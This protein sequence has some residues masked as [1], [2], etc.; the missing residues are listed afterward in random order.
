[1]FY[2]Y[3][4]SFTQFLAFTGNFSFTVQWLSKWYI[5]S[6]DRASHNR[7]LDRELPFSPIPAIDLSYPSDWIP[8]HEFCPFCDEA[9]VQCLWYRTSNFHEVTDQFLSYG[10]LCDAGYTDFPFPQRL[11][12]IQE[13]RASLE[14]NFPQ[15]DRCNCHSGESTESF[16]DYSWVRNELVGYPSQPTAQTLELVPATYSFSGVP[17]HVH[18]EVYKYTSESLEQVRARYENNPLVELACGFPKVTLPFLIFV[19]GSPVP[20]LS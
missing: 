9:S 7:F 11:Q 17:W 10:D 16:L 8:S 4:G 20:F 2:G 14:N 6:L 5:S 12:R 15:S 13:L 1:M 18:G 3:R 19:R